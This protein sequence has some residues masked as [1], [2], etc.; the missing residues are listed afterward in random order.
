MLKITKTPILPDRIRRIQGSFSFIPHKFVTAGFFTSLNQHELLIYFL[1]VIV[2]DRNGLSYYS[3][4]KLCTMLK[5]TLDEFIAARNGLIDKSLIAF[6]G[7]IFQVL[8]LPDKVVTVGQKSS[9]I[10]DDCES[11]DPLTIRRL[12]YKSLHGNNVQHNAY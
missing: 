1:L 6:D 11:K 4:D 12:I 10:Q 2:G 3:Q 7:F 9:T 5:M 8:A